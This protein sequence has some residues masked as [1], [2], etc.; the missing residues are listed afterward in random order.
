MLRFPA[1]TIV[2]FFFIRDKSHPQFL[3]EGRGKL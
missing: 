1:D 2:F 3:E